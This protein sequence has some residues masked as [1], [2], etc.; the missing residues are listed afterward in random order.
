MSPNQVWLAPL[1]LC[2]PPLPASLAPS[3]SDA[4]TPH[5]YW[6]VSRVLTLAIV[7]K[8]FSAA[9]VIPLMML[10]F[11]SCSLLTAAVTNFGGLFTLRILLGVFESPMLPSIVYY[12]SSFY[13]RGELA[14]RIGVYYAAS[15]ISGAFSGLLAFGIFQINSTKLHGWQYLFV[16]PIFPREAE[17]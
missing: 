17:Y 10:G 2:P 5:L 9:R 16:S 6:S 12:L 4:L 14:R 11:G 8:R 1:H 13:T 3:C 7:A 15:S